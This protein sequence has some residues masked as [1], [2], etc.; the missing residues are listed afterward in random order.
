VAAVRGGDDAA[1]LRCVVVEI[2]GL[3]TGDVDV[4]FGH[5]CTAV[6]FDPI[7]GFGSGSIHPHVWHDPRHRLRLLLGS[8]PLAP[9]I[10]SWR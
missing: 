6:G 1:V 5:G 7:D 2:L 3:V 8:S 4:D 10:R 9:T